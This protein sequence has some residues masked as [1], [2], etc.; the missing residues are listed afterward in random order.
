MSSVITVHPGGW[1]ETDGVRLRCALGRS[2]LTPADQKR[3]GDG[4][5]PQGR[6]PVRRIWYR[7]DRVEPPETALPVL[8]IQPG[9]GWCDDPA[10]PGYNRWVA[11]P[12]PVHHED[13]F[14]ADPVYD[15]VAELGY[16]DDPPVPGAG[17]AIFMH[18]ARDDYAPTEGCIALSETD[19][20]R[21]IRALQAST[22]IAIGPDA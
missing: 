2:G 18:V 16:N 1:L 21:V 9:D 13:L 6:W 3:E 7:A 11:L 20:R 10:A 4:A 5:T 14:R 22:V 12:A 8:V 15:L 19:L 17:S